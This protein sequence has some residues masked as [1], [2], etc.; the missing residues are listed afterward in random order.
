MN[1]K[2]NNEISREADVLRIAYLDGKYILV[3]GENENCDALK[4]L[5]KNWELLE[6][7]QPKKNNNISSLSSFVRNFI[8]PTLSLMNEGNIARGV[9]NKSDSELEMQAYELEESIKIAIE[10]V[11]GNKE[12]N[13]KRRIGIITKVTNLKN[14]TTQSLLDSM[15]QI[16][17]VQ[18]SLDCLKLKKLISQTQEKLEKYKQSKFVNMRIYTERKNEIDKLSDS[19]EV[20]YRKVS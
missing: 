7:F 12:A 13:I 15:S 1:Y 17:R 16:Q 11:E 19:L 6:D 18:Y 9:K 5:R 14:N 10:G 2:L 8:Q 4:D 20:S 3:Q